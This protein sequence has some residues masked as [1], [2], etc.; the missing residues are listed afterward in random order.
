VSKEKTKTLFEI[1]T[2]FDQVENNKKFLLS[3]HKTGEKKGKNVYKNAS[4]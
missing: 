1:Y 2:V 4:F 3:K